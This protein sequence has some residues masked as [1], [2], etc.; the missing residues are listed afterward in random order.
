MG[1]DQV[2]L[3]WVSFLRLDRVMG[4]KSELESDPTY[5]PVKSGQKNLEGRVRWPVIKI[6]IHT[7]DA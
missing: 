6:H 5:Q 7:E 1:L 2:L 4:L 3:L